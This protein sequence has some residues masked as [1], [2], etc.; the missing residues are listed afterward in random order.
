MNNIYIYIY[1][2]TSKTHV[3]GKGQQDTRNTRG[4]SLPA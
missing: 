2:E 4:T 3:L 1:I